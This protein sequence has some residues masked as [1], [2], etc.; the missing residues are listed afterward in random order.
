MWEKAF[1]EPSVFAAIVDARPRPNKASP[2][3]RGSTAPPAT[4][5]EQHR[6]LSDAFR[7]G[8]KRG[9]PR[10]LDVEDLLAGEA[11]AHSVIT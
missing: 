9:C 3:R 8:L 11:D 10:L 5:D 2:S 4:R 6:M 1:C 7:T